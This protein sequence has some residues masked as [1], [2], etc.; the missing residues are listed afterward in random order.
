MPTCSSILGPRYAKTD[1]GTVCVAL[2]DTPSTHTTPA[3]N[4]TT[5]ARTKPHT[6][7]SMSARTHLNCPRSWLG[8]PGLAKATSDECT[9][10]HSD[11]ATSS[12]TRR[13]HRAHTLAA[14]VSKDRLSLEN[15]KTASPLPFLCHSVPISNED[16]HGDKNNCKR[17]IQP[18]MQPPELDSRDHS[19]SPAAHGRRMR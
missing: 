5:E 2:N 11:N 17:Q 12:E 18:L 3:L 15:I 4:T 16:K 8:S 19:A 13:I 10:T 7:M 9:Q 1:A 14:H 6:T